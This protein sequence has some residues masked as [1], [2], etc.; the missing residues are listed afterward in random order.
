MLLKPELKPV[1][2]FWA[3]ETGVRRTTG[4]NLSPPVVQRVV[5]VG[6]G[7]GVLAQHLTDR[8][9]AGSRAAA[10]QQRGKPSETGNSDGGAGLTP[11]CL[12]AEVVGAA[13]H[14]GQRT[15]KLM[16]ALEGG[17]QQPVAHLLHLLRDITPSSASSPPHKPAPFRCC[18]HIHLTSRTLASAAAQG[19]EKPE[20]TLGHW[21]SPGSASTQL[22]PNIST[23]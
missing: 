17:M 3:M 6:A 11:A 7:A 1:F 20:G 15:D 5:G 14:V 19:E 10:R 21:A 4:R 13:G 8:I 16:A 22:F 23:S 9:S 12:Q 2:W 18:C